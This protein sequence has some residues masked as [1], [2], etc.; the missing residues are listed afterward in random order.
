LAGFAATLT[1]TA[2]PP[3][4][5]PKRLQKQAEA[6]KKAED[7][8][9]A[10]EA[11][12]TDDAKKADDLAKLEKTL[13]QPAKLPT[14]PVTKDPAELART[15]DAGI[16]AK[17]A[18]RKVPASPPC[19]DSEFI[20][21][22]YL[23]LTGVIPPADKART[24]IDSR[25][26]DKR[27]K[28]IDELLASS[29]YGKHQADVWMSLLVQKTSDNRR[30]DFAPFRDWLTEQ[31]N[32]NTSWSA[33]V[34]DLIT[35]N[36]AY[37]KVP[38][39]GFY[40]SNNTV[41]KMTDQVTKLFL[42][43][44]MQCAQCHDHKFED[45]KQKE[46]WSFTQF[47]MKVGIGGG[48]GAKVDDTAVVKEGGPIN[49]KKSPLP[50]AAMSL[51]ASFL[52]DG[53]P[54]KLSTPEPYRPVLAKW[55]TGE[56]NP[57]FAKAMVNRV[58]GQ[59]FGTGFVNP[60]TDMGPN[61]TPSHPE[62]LAGLAHQFAGG[63]YDLKKLIRAVCRTSAY[64]RS[65][66]P[67]PGNEKDESLFSH[68]AVKVMSP[69]V[70]YDSTMAVMGGPAAGPAVRGPMAQQKGA[71]VG[72]RE[73][74][75]NFFLAGADATNSTEYEAGIPQALKLMNSRQMTNPA[76]VRSLI[77]LKPVKTEAIEKLYLTTLARRPTSEEAAKM[78]DYITKSPIEMDGYADI[79]W[80]L[81][82]CS[83]FTMVR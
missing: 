60:L 5:Q 47:F 74:F 43:V 64:Q 34:S 69:E 42:G 20:R 68:V 32:D 2:Q 27:T 33:I 61:E 37:G 6:Q 19:T 11:K 48:A 45:W 57:Y 56:K 53:G 82:N 49:R 23:D 83:E 78:A 63:G 79:L 67:L 25:E 14:G 12:S 7:D 24:F 54:L 16:D 28:L 72:R 35:A 66:K 18:A 50:E 59:F 75:V 41:D 15:I 58:W 1:A 51:P 39:T 71:P 10:A 62:L 13:K 17:L 26:T 22:A 76:A 44:S 9:K 65:S 81:L 31:F 21:R 4:Q 80:A 46:Y 40:L 3:A 38:A 52:R 30:V 73:Q 29:N 36:G 70:L 8:R 55:V 77:G